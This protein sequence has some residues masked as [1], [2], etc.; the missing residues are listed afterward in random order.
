[1]TI[2][3]E[4]KSEPITTSKYFV[5]I[6]ESPSANDLLNGRTEGRLLTETLSLSKIISFYNLTVDYSSFLEA[7]G[8]RLYEAMLENAGVPILHFSTHGNEEGIKLTNNV[9]LKWHELRELLL[10]INKALNG[11]LIICM[12]SCSGFSGCRMA[13]SLDAKLPPFYGLIGPN[14]TPTWSETAVAFVTFYHLLF[15]GRTVSQAVEAMC[16]ASGKNDFKVGSGDKARQAWIDVIKEEKQQNRL[17]KLRRLI[18]EQQM[19][20]AQNDQD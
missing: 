18:A 1:M 14:T 7:L 15:N 17:E 9:F 5:H 10:P 3:K 6:I 8:P 11:G 19:N 2:S 12:S 16:T 20:F 4:I 13:M